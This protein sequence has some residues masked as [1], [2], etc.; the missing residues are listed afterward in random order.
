MLCV[1]TLLLWVFKGI[2]DSI[3]DDNYDNKNKEELEQNAENKK[4]SHF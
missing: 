4:N 1:F 3:K 2:L